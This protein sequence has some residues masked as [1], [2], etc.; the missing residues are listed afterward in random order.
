MKP[1]HSIKVIPAG[2]PGEEGPVVDGGDGLVHERVRLDESQG[3]V[4]EGGGRLVG[5]R[6][7]LA[8]AASRPAAANKRKL[9]HQDATGGFH[10]HRCKNTDSCLVSGDEREGDGGGRRRQ[11]S[12]VVIFFSLFADD[13][14]AEQS[15]RRQQENR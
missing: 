3:V 13:V 6:R 7:A 9:K 15:P 10:G 14:C 12:Y 5:R 11:V 8:G 1:V 4:G 2:G